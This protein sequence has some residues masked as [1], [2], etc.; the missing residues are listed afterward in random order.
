MCV[1]ASEC[2]LC[3]AVIRLR[4]VAGREEGAVRRTE[5]K[6][7]RLVECVDK[8]GREGKGRLV[9]TLGSGWRV[10]RSGARR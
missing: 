7:G 8:Q 10:A 4:D 1:W 3:D 6:F 5:S 9:L 2:M